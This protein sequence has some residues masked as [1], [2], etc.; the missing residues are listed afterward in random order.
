M[1]KIAARRA[2]SALAA[3]PIVLIANSTETLA[4]ISTQTT[5]PIKKVSDVSDEF[6]FDFAVPI[7][8][9]IEESENW[10]EAEFSDGLDIQATEIINAGMK[11]E[12]F[13]QFQTFIDENIVIETG[14]DLPTIYISAARGQSTR[15]CR[16]SGICE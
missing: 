10:D 15:E 8:S 16:I 2:I 11:A 4:G 7:L 12:P 13:D 5:E 1:R 6:N 9:N 3:M 14:S